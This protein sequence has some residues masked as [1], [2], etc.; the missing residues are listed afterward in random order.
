MVEQ[1]RLFTVSLALFTALVVAAPVGAQQPVSPEPLHAVPRRDTTPEQRKALEELKAERA[2]LDSLRARRIGL[3]SKIDSLAKAGILGSDTTI[4]PPLDR[5]RAVDAEIR[6]ALYELMTG[7]AIAALSRLRPLNAG[8]E[9]AERHFLIAECYYRLGMDD[10]LR[11]EAAT[12]AAMPEAS[13]FQPLMQAQLLLAAYRDGDYARAAEQARTLGADQSGITSLLGGLAAYRLGQEPAARSAFEAVQATSGPYKTY[14]QYMLTLM[15]LKSDTANGVATAMLAL[16]SLVPSAQNPASDQLHLT[17][18]QLA[19]EGAQYDRS[20]TEAGLVSA[21]GGLRAPALFT[22]AWA[23]FRGGKPQAAGDLFATYARDYPQLPARDEGRL[24]H[25]QVAL[26]LHQDDSASRAFK[27]VAD[28]ISAE[29]Q[30]L[31]ANASGLRGG[32]RLLVNARVADV[33]LLGDVAG[34]KAVTFPDLAVS[35]IDALSVAVPNAPSVTPTVPAPTPVSVEALAQ[36]LDSA[37][38]DSAG[39]AKAGVSA[40]APLLRRAVFMP[41]SDASTRGELVKGLA[42]LRDA[43]VGVELADQ[44]VRAEKANILLQVANLKRMREMI[45][46]EQDSLRSGFGPLAVAEDSLARVT[47]NVD[48]AYFTLHR[49]IMAQTS[50][51][52]D[53]S[54]E[55]NKKLDSVQ[56]S[57]SGSASTADLAYLEQEHETANIYRRIADEVDAHLDSAIG[58]N[59]AFALRDT[60]RQRGERTRALIVQTRAAGA[61]AAAAVDSAQAHVETGRSETRLTLRAALQAA[62]ARRETVANALVVTVDRELTA[63]GIALAAAM[64]RDL[65]AAEFGSATAS[66]FRAIGSDSTAGPGAS[67][68]SAP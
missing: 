61:V 8:T 28:S 66:F 1:R 51:L 21:T 18:A 39:A 37:G 67:S 30:G 46:G 53:L 40:G 44:S 52:R 26:Q 27:S 45:Q 34:G 9:S 68:G 31:G 65:E 50:D 22:G 55:N 11:T 33:L 7:D 19:Y 32:A 49:L 64:R 12:L 5:G 24:M 42:N 36:R 20:A 63:R 16:D 48:S 38:I 6:V 56:R 2:Q 62:Q 3:Q 17:L 23:S 29:T 14:A 13:R 25:A 59:P 15:S 47:A 35:G 43:D 60:V 57:L 54:T 10:S 4:I 41:V 58:H